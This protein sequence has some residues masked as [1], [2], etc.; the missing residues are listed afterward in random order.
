MLHFLK[1][2]S[3]IARYHNTWSSS[4]KQQLVAAIKITQ[5]TQR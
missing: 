1:D 3:A 4:E 2:L 5:T